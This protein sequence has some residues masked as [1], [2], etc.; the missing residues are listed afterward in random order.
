[1]TNYSKS[2]ILLEAWKAARMDN[3]EE[4]KKLVPSCVSPD[5]SVAIL[6]PDS[7]D[8][9]L[10]MTAAAHGAIQCTQYLINNNANVNAKNF[11]GYTALHWASY[12]GREEVISKLRSNN[13][14]D[15]ESRTED[16]KT[17]L[18][19]AAYRG[20]NSVIVELLDR[21]N[22]D[23]NAISSNGWSAMHYAII[24]NQRATAELLIQR[25][26]DMSMLD[27]QKRSIQ[28]FA[29]LYKRKWFPLLE[30]KYMKKD[31]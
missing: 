1:M 20:N 29:C 12:C 25:K 8:H 28:E 24:S 18:H 27:A 16:G 6:N 5:D 15:V 10:L 4:L 26:I 30:E 31:D 7:H 21:F 9:T 2:K 14:L 22:A 11:A 23:I 17:P 3:I 13:T 19:I